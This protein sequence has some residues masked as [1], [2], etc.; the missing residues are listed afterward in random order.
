MRFLSETSIIY[1]TQHFPNNFSKKFEIVINSL[2][3]ND[4]YTQ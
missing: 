4:D 1:D 2:F 3:Q